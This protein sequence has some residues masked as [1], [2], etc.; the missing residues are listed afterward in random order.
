MRFASL[1]HTIR[2]ILFSLMTLLPLSMHIEASAKELTDQVIAR[3]LEDGILV[4]R[5]HGSVSESGLHMVTLRSKE[6]FFKYR[7]FPM[8]AANPEVDVYLND[9]S[10][11]DQIE[12]KGQFVR[13]RA[14]NIH[15]RIT[16][17]RVLDA[18][19]SAIPRQ[20]QRN[21]PKLSEN[22]ILE[23]RV[24]AV[25]AKK[26]VVVLERE[27]GIFPV[28]INPVNRDLTKTL[29]RNDELAV[30]YQIAP[31][32]RKPVHLRLQNTPAA[33]FVTKKIV[34]IHGKTIELEGSLVRFEQS[35]QINR[36]IFAIQEQREG[37]NRYYTL[38]NFQNM[39]TFEAIA[40]KLELRWNEQLAA[41]KPGR[42]LEINP[43]IKI[44]VKGRGNLVSKSQANPQLLIDSI[45]DIQ[46]ISQ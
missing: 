15:F 6:N 37:F 31:Y 2:R 28:F 10:R 42:N 29:Y 44:R 4:G 36:P 14:E 22:G 21:I 7:L 17:L 5:V 34:E 13:N 16:R 41:K 35:P 39:Q 27:D 25:D 26:G 18:W 12:L 11:H 3:H 38:V 19:N 8:V 9:L 20:Y 45:D 1:F 43:E 23:G 33:I 32:P 40:A 30:K 46:F 24:H